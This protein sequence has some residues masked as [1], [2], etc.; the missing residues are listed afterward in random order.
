M[1][2]LI[3]CKDQEYNTRYEPEAS[4][5]LFL[6]YLYLYLPWDWD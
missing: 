3:L 5:G 1:T 2:L 4:N 6:L